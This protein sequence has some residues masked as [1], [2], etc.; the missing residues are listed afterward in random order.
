VVVHRTSIE[1]DEALL[2]GT[3][4]V[5]GTTGIR[6]TVEGAMRE[7]IRAHRRTQLLERIRTGAGVDRSLSVLGESRPVR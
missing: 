7:V 4:Q 1:L 6:E 5:L 3:R 2:E